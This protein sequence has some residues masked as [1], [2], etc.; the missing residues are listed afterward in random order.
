M[1]FF[2]TRHT[3]G[4]NVFSWP[5]V[6]LLRGFR[7]LR[8]NPVPP[9]FPSGGFGFL[10]AY[11]LVSMLPH[12]PQPKG[13][14]FPVTFPPPPRKT[15]QILVRSFGSFPL[16]PLRII[17]NPLGLIN[18][19][20]F[21]FPFFYLIPL[22]LGPFPNSLWKDKLTPSPHQGPPPPLSPVCIDV[23]FVHFFSPPLFPT[24]DIL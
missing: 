15:Q 18:T 14:L 4:S 2:Q 8:D 20:D 19:L 16:N 23:H 21:S 12:A 24:R 10:G 3:P 9:P 13:G 6:F 1:C 22:R 11:F 17:P 7:G 5:P